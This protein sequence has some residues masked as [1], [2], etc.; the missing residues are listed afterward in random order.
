[1]SGLS[2]KASK[3]TFRLTTEDY[4]SCLDQKNSIIATLQAEVEQLRTN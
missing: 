1:M 3:G 2:R 4:S